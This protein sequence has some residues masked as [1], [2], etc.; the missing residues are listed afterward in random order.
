MADLALLDKGQ[1]ALSA[2]TLTDVFTCAS[3]RM[4]RV[5][6]VFCNRSTATTIRL[7]IAKD[8][9]GD[10]DSQYLYYDYVLP[11]NDVIDDIHLTL[12]EG[13]VLRAYA[14]SANVSVN[15]IVDENN[16]LAN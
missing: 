1:Y 5:Q 4:T 16:I 15:V 14:A 11:A 6:V 9:A 12:T 8:G 13:D 7:S 2:A 10:T 3:G